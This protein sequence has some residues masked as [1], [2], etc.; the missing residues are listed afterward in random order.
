MATAACITVNGVR[1]AASPF[2]V[3]SASCVT[4]CGVASAA[5]RVAWAGNTAKRTL[6]QMLPG[7]RA[8]WFNA[9]GTPK[10]EIYKLLA[11]VVRFLDNMKGLTL[12]Q[13]VS[14][15]RDAQAQVVAVQQIA[16]GALTVANASADAV[17]TASQVAVSN[18]LAGATSIPKVQRFKGDYLP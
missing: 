2:K 9:D 11:E 7:P 17:N 18:G 13:V 8:S 10:P 6:L 3:A 4:R 16:T 12:P 5:T 14:Q 15:V 1:S